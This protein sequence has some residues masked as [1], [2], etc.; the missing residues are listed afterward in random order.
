[1]NQSN[2]KPSP[3]HPQGRGCN[4][5]L[6]AHAARRC[7]GLG[8]RRDGNGFEIFV[9]GNLDTRISRA[10]ETKRRPKAPSAGIETGPAAYDG[11]SKRYSLSACAHGI[12][13][14][15]D[16]GT[17]DELAGL[18]QDA[19]PDTKLRIG[20]SGGSATG[21]AKGRQVA[22]D[23]SQCALALAAIALDDKAC[24]SSGERTGEAEAILATGK[25]K[26]KAVDGMK[27]AK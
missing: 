18:G 9:T 5:Q 11:R 6:S 12:G 10:A 14:I 16:I 4:I 25:R 2:D 22:C 26:R 21:R 13:G 24:S 1:M 15:F 3:N 19:G 7:G 17:G 23:D 27:K 8:I 20:T